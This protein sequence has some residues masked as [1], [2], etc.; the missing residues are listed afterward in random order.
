MTIKLV[1]YQLDLIFLGTAVG[2]DA[3][4]EQNTTRDRSAEI[5]T[6]SGGKS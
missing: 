3:L 6:A 4:A 2:L 1:Y 5:E